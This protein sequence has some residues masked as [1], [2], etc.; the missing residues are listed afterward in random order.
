[1]CIRDRLS[2]DP[3]LGPWQN[4]QRFAWYNLATSMGWNVGR[5]L[6]NAV[7]IAAL[8]APLL[9]LLRRTGRRAEVVQPAIAAPEAE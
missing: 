5:A 6:T 4:L 8:G 1:M 2:F 7:L 3:A 9:R